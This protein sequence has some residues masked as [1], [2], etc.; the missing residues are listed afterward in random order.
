VDE[1][2]VPGLATWALESQ[3]PRCGVGS[4]PTMEASYLL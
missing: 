1:E 2:D 3:S 4:P